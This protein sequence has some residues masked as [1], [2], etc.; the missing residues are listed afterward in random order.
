MA[1][2]LYLYFAAINDETINFILNLLEPKLIHNEEIQ[3]KIILA[4][5]L[6]ELGVTEEESKKYLSTKYKNLLEE[7]VNLKKEDALLSGTFN[8]L[9]GIV[10]NSSSCRYFQTILILLIFSG[11]IINLYLDYNKFKGRNTQSSIPKLKKLLEN[12]SCQSLIEFFR[13]TDITN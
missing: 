1:E 4:N 7:Q 9:H 12:F 11:A 3:K 6:I 2:L 10:L 8:K 13:P 5:A